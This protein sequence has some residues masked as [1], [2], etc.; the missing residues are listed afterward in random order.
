MKAQKALLLVLLATI[1]TIIT[2]CALLAS[3]YIERYED[4]SNYF[5]ANSEE[6]LIDSKSSDK[7]IIDPDVPIS[8][9]NKE[10]ELMEDSRI[11][12]VTGRKGKHIKYLNGHYY[13]E[14]LKILREQHNQMLNYIVRKANSAVANNS[15][16]SVTLKPQL[17][18]SNDPHDYLSLARYYWPNPKTEN[19]IPYIVRDGYSNPEIWTVEDYVLLR[20]LMAEIQAT[21]LGFDGWNYRGK[22]NQSIKTAVD[23]L[24]PFA[25]NGGEGWKFKNIDGF[26]MSKYIRIL[27]FSW[28]VWGDDKYLDAIKILKPKAK[29]EKTS[30][31]S[32]ENSLCI[33]SL[34][35]DGALWPCLK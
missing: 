34:L 23:Y 29:A 19:G 10:P 8:I 12:M 28:I 7:S 21:H 11:K 1:L 9:V 15:V 5:E 18:P 35:N 30:Q 3:R 32:E 13:T 6:T 16:Y 2:I 27:E 4:S 31:A 24:L 33:W 17:A 25:L 20:K 26:K 14:Y 22:N